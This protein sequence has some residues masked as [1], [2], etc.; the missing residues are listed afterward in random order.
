M[1]EVGGVGLVDACARTDDVEG[2][3]GEQ[4][5]FEHVPEAGPG[6]YVCL[7]EDGF[8]GGGGVFGEEGLGFGAE[9]QVGEEDVA[10]AGE[11]EGCEC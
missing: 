7:E 4:G 11:E 5:G 6:G 3:E 8:G 2:G 9:G 1:P 10:S